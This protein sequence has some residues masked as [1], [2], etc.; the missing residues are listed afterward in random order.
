MR[1]RMQIEATAAAAEA[2][3]PSSIASMPS[4][5]D[6]VRGTFIDGMLRRDEQLMRRLQC[7]W[8]PIGRTLTFIHSP[9]LR[10]ARFQ[11]VGALHR[12]DSY[13]HE[14]CGQR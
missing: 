1:M 13:T 4:G 14:H 6:D 3:A 7:A 2:L 11:D 5:A 10:V 8:T 12:V 9:V